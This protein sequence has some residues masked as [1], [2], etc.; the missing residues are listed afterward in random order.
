[1]LICIYDTDS[2]DHKIFVKHCQ[3]NKYVFKDFKFP[4]HTAIFDIK[5]VFFFLA[6][7]LLKCTLNHTFPFPI[8]KK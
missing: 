4:P 7:P 2:N 1:M 6:A 8:C 3:F 5:Y